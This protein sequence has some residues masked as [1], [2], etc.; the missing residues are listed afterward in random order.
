MSND[1]LKLKHGDQIEAD[2]D[3]WKVLGIGRQVDGFIYVHV[4]STTRFVKQRNGER[5]IQSGGWY[6]P[7]NGTIRRN[8]ELQDYDPEN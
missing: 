3:I 7:S 4:A 6:N 8:L 2:G 5:P 1:K